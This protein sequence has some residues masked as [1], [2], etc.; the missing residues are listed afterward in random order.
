MHGVSRSAM[1]GVIDLTIDENSLSSVRSEDI[2]ASNSC[3]LYSPLAIHDSSDKNNHEY[4]E[5][6]SYV[7]AACLVIKVV[8]AA[9]SCRLVAPSN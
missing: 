8:S 9:N 5:S 2:V 4:D 7:I 6:L 1:D 3:E